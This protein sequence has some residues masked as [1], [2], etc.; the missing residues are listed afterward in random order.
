MTK[1]ACYDDDGIWGVGDI[2][3]QAR[4]EA[5][6]FVRGCYPDDEEAANKA[7]ADLKV[8]QISD[9]L[10]NRAAGE[11]GT[12]SGR[13]TINY[14]DIPFK[15]DEDGVLV[16]DQDKA[17]ADSDAGVS[18]FI[19]GEDDDE[20]GSGPPEVSISDDPAHDAPATDPVDPDKSTD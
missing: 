20:D 2:E 5:E 12:L 15:L 9:D 18:D 17:D 10:I 4:A 6:G 8:A 11:E 7:V 1:I 13:V 19:E 3:E 16:F 14:T